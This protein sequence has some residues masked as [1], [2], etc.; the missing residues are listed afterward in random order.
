MFAQ[1]ATST[2]ALTI[3]GDA[4]YGQHFAGRIDEVRIY[5]TARSPSEIQAD[6][7]TPVG[8][9]GPPDTQAPTAPS[10]LSATAVRRVR[11]TCLDGSTDNVGGD[12]LSGRALP[13]GGLFELR[14]GR[15]PD[16]DDLQRHG[17]GGGDELQLSGAGGGCGRRI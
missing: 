5:N 17:P 7:N 4:F 14:P 15:D 9:P 8:A 13:G 10:A 2:G 16:R 1:I 11:S 3:G 12:R 6:M